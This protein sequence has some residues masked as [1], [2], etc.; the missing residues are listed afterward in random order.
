MNGLC[1]RNP[2]E[3]IRL[4]PIDIRHPFV[5][6]IVTNYNYEKYIIPC[7]KSIARQTYTYFKCVIVD[8][9]ST[10]NSIPL[11]REFV[12]SGEA[13][14]RFSVI[15]HT[16][17]GGQMEAFKT[18]LKY[19]DSVFVV[20]VDADDL[21]LEDFLITHVKTHLNSQ[22]V[23]F[24]SSDQYQINENNELIAGTHP[25]HTARG[26]LHYI[27]PRSI[28]TPFWIWATTSSMMY[29]KTILELVIPDDTDHFRICADNYICHFANLLGGSLL[30]PT[31]HGCYRR[32]GLNNFSS[33]PLVGG[34]HPT[35]DMV[36]HPRHEIIRTSILRHF[37]MNHRSFTAL[38][39]DNLFA[40]TL[41]HISTPK[42]LLKIKQLYSECLPGKSA[43]FFMKLAFISWYQ[44]KK[45]TLKKYLNFLKNN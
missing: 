14:G 8:D 31:I 26:K 22:P 37:L 39:S 21:L 7:L 9:C 33:N 27:S 10:D 1:K 30:I 19:V 3:D 25:D 2:L 23:A 18:G 42:D 11:I 12:A 24:T 6:V 32:H 13:A 45:V 20:L 34:V 35:G 15:I 36:K 44:N 4:K 40:L 43:L 28:I 38:L 41:L 5:T 16:V 29:R 17:N